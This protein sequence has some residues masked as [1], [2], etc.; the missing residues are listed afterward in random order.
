M[1]EFKNQNILITGG[2]SGM[3]LVTAGLFAS[4]GANVFI[5]GRSLEQGNEALR[6]LKQYDGRNQYIIL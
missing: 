3:G 5:S 4:E 2:T 1:N 6:S